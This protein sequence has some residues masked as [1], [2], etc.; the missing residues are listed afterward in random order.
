MDPC[1]GL[2]RNLANRRLHCESISHWRLNRPST[3]NT[4]GRLGSVPM[5]ILRRRYF[6][7]E[8]VFISEY[9][10]LVTKV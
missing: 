1:C 4:S 3:G 7:D 2:G 10:E 5:D 6:Y 9:E 8:I